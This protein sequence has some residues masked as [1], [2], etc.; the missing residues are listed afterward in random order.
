MLRTRVRA[1]GKQPPG[2]QPVPTE[3]A[4]WM[5]AGDSDSLA[6]LWGERLN[7]AIAAE[8]NG[9]GRPLRGGK[10]GEAAAAQ[11]G[12]RQHVGQDNHH[13]PAGR[14]DHCEPGAGWTG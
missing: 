4:C 7:F 8:L 10:K 13:L 6:W 2:L 3:P 5:D 14:A 9:L 12:G 11:E 1:A